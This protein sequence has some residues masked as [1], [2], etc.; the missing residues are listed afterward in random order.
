MIS[1]GVSKLG[2]TSFFFVEPG[3]KINDQYYRNALLGRMLP[4]MNNLS[5]GDY[6]FLQDGARSDTAKATLEYLNE[7]CP[8]YVK[9]DHWPPKSPNLNVLDFVI[10]RDLEKK[11]WKNKP[12]DVESL[13]QAII[14]EWRLIARNNR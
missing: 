7:N 14:K 4:E 11:L 3:V 5:R 2:R 10:W 6:S 1:A 9:P 13:R 12:H 8:A